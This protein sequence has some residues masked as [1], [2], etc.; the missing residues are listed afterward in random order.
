MV[1]GRDKLEDEADRKVPRQPLVLGE[2]TDYVARGCRRVPF[3]LR[4]LSELPNHLI[5]SK[6]VTDLYKEVGRGCHIVLQES[7]K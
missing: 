6:R 2:I 3:N 4:K 1:G 5:E 7:K